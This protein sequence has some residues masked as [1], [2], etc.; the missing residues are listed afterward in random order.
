MKCT[1]VAE[2]RRARLQRYQGYMR[3][4]VPVAWRTGY[5]E[6]AEAVAEAER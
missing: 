3:L 4:Y 5:M 2:A 1:G 6:A